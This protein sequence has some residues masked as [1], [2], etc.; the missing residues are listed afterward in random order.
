M[1]VKCYIFPSLF[2]PY[3]WVTAVDHPRFLDSLVNAHGYMGRM[4]CSRQPR[5]VACLFLLSCVVI[6][7]TLGHLDRSPA[8]IGCAFW[9]SGRFSSF[10]QPCL[11]WVTPPSALSPKHRVTCLQ[12]FGS[13]CFCQVSKC[14]AFIY[15]EKRVFSFFFSDTHFT[16][17]HLPHPPV[18]LCSHF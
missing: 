10:C 7:S 6:S 15:Q 9:Y 16:I 12:P 3:P 5:V 11:C 2:S 1:T 14:L 18:S 4:Q 17:T 8:L 13:I